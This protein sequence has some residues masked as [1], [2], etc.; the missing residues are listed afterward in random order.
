MSI[1]PTRRLVW[2]LPAPV[3]VAHTATTGLGAVQHR[4]ARAHQAEVRAGRHGDRCLVHDLLVRRVGVGQH[5]LVDLLS[6]PPYGLDTLGEAN[7][8]L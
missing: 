2:L 7:A 1:R 3:R 6:R 8:P 5:D 4:R